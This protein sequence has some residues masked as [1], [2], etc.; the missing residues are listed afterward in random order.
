MREKTLIVLEG[1]FA[2]QEIEIEI[3]KGIKHKIAIIDNSL[4]TV[5]LK[6]NSDNKEL[7]EK[8]YLTSDL[9]FNDFINMCNNIKADVIKAAN[10]ALIKNNKRNRRI[11]TNFNK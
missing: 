9:S 7:S 6:T 8:V 3:C 10:T 5:A 11:K 2:G 1:L 4:V